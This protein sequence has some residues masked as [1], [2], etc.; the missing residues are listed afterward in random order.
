MKWSE[1]L[2]EVQSFFKLLQG[3]YAEALR[4]QDEPGQGEVAGELSLAYAAVG[5]QILAD[6]WG[7]AF[8]KAMFPAPAGRALHTH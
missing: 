5:N 3:Q 6:R 7:D 1:Q 2:V 8:V 4:E